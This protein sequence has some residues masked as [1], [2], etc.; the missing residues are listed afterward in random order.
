MRHYEVFLEEIDM[1]K[2]LQSAMCR[3]LKD[4]LSSDFLLIASGFTV[5]TLLA[6]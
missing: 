2:M 3:K 6:T 1:V 5:L 4:V